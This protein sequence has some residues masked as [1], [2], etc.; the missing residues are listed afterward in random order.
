VHICNLNVSDNIIILA[1]AYE[2]MMIMCSC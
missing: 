2:S 1:M